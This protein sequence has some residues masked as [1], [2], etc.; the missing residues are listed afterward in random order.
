MPK[1]YEKLTDIFSL[2]IDPGLIDTPP[3]Y[4]G[5]NFPYCDVGPEW[6]AHWTKNELHSICLQATKQWQRGFSAQIINSVEQSYYEL[7]L[8]KNLLVK[9]ASKLTLYPAPVTYTSPTGQT[10]K[11]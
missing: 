6:I 5:R 1:T 3:C 2:S 9:D 11:C 7:L 4:L 10:I 8:S